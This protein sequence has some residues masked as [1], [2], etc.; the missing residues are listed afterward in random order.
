MK[1]KVL[2]AM[3]V[4]LCV[5]FFSVCS[6][7][8]MP[9]HE[10]RLTPAELSYIKEH[11]VVTLGT[12]ET[13][14]PFV[15]KNEDG[16]YSG[17]DVDVTKLITEMTGL[18][19]SFDQ[20]KWAEIIKKA[21]E[22]KIDGL[23]SSVPHPS[24]AKF[25]NFTPPYAKYSTVVLVRKDN[26][27]RLHSLDDLDGKRAAVM[28]GNI[29][30]LNGVKKTGAN[31]EIVWEPNAYELIKSVATG[32][33]D[34]LIAGEPAFYL[35]AKL[36]LSG[37]LESAFPTGGTTEFCF[38][39]R[40]DQ[41]E[42]VSIFNKALKS[43]PQEKLVAIWNKWLRGSAWNPVGDDGR[44]KLTVPEQEFLS[45]NHSLGV[46]VWSDRPP[47]AFF[48]SGGKFRGM[49]ADFMHLAGE[50]LGSSVK[51]LPVRSSDP[52]EDLKQKKCDLVMMC[53]LS[54]RPEPGIAYTMPYISFPY[55]IAAKM[56]KQ[57]QDEFH[58]EDNQIFA[59]VKG[60]SAIS[61]L[62]A[63]YPG[64][65]L[66]ET[67]SVHSG[68]RKVRD[69]EIYALISTFPAVT[70]E[71]QKNFLTELKVIAQTPLKAQYAV[72]TR[73]SSADLNR[74]FQKIV[75]NIGNSEKRQIIN[76]WMAIKYE[77]GVDYSL[78]WKILFV[79]VLVVGLILYRNRVLQ[80]AK[81]KAE[82]ELEAERETVRA[83]LNF[84]D[85]ISNEYRSPLSVISSNL[86]LIEEK[87]GREGEK[88]VS[89]ELERMRN[90]TQRLLNIFDKSL[91]KVRIESAEQLPEN[92]SVDLVE[93]VRTVMKDVQSTHPDHIIELE[94]PEDSPLTVSGD[95]ELLSLAVVNLLDNGCKYSEPDVP[96]VVS[97]FT[98][99]QTVTLRVRDQGVGMHSDDQLR[100]FEKYY[101]SSNVG[102]KRGAG[103]GLYIVKKIIDL[104][105]GRIRV[106][107]IPGAGTTF[108]AEFPAAQ[109][110]Q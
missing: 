109:S 100:V 53:E 49:V 99:G 75:G 47:F 18:K 55:V 20:G 89:K 105:A 96:V 38:S 16:S 46:S 28:R 51:L 106:S 9:A 65:N 23:T 104:H 8:A 5:L 81:R 13:F 6:W 103:I 69:G 10:L 56:D 15:H 84:I 73:E 94:F 57:F 37:F 66:R 71:I 34:F 95:S 108:T 97:L 25:F 35:I 92:H 27:E 30:M 1:V 70:Y 40:N 33:S 63:E 42:L 102:K 31:V 74:I 19:F 59:V 79:S 72:A 62:R 91:A 45:V 36:G 82:A 44:I 12:D 80:C 87:T 107:S 29:N 54:D 43:I 11:P 68:L 17:I 48:P 61:R 86:D 93:I 58:P 110:R 98:S 22:R 14:D 50:D 21:E 24:R 4:L 26:P 3:H 7:A 2:I 78:V 85:M 60:T 41:P 88:D 90:S 101:R 52:L 67:E 83:N 76:K 77:K 39:L 64:L 32:R